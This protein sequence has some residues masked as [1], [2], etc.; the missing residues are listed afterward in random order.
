MLLYQSQFAMAEGCAAAAAAD[1]AADASIAVKETG[2]F[3][4]IDM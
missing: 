3:V 4:V 1:A 2:E